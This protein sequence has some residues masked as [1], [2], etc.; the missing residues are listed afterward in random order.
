L[1]SER[2]PFFRAPWPVMALLAVILAAYGMQS[3]IGADQVALNLGFAP[4]D[5]T[6]GRFAPL[7][8]ALFIH[9][10]WAHVLVNSAF[11]LAFGA[12]VSRR[13]GQDGLG[14]LAFV[15]FFLICGAIANLGYAAVHPRDPNVV[16]GA[17][18]AA[19][20]LM[21]AASRLMTPG[22]GLA[23]LFSRPVLSMA[24]A[25][26]GINLL[27]GAA[28]FMGVAGL[29]PGAAGNLVAWEAHLFGYAAGLFLFAPLLWLIRRA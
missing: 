27:L 7:I 10:G 20:G 4:A 15:G 29:T 9:G 17:S 3:Y 18:G 22:P 6:H 19:A 13:L 14:A 12:P 23:P 8:L 26:V 16:V 25:W 11:I 21:A 1:E 28:Q 5:L 2:E 24:G